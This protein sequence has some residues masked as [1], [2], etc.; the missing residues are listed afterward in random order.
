MFSGC[1]LLNEGVLGGEE[2]VL[3]ITAVCDED[4]L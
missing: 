3:D 2:A 1:E 4:F